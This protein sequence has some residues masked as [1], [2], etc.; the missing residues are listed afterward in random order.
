MAGVTK[1]RGQKDDQR[2]AYGLAE[3]PRTGSFDKRIF[4]APREFTLFRELARTHQSI[5]RDLVRVQVRLKTLFR[6]R[7]ILTREREAGSAS[8]PSRPTNLASLPA[9]RWLTEAP[10]PT[11]QGAYGLARWV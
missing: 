2:D 3:K 10:S 9:F 8:S 4:K 5:G 11:S 6:S 1:S 7:G